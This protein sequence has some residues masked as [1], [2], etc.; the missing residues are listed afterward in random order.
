MS[1]CNHKCDPDAPHEAD[2]KHYLDCPVWKNI[3]G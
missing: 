3:L 2:E 1:E